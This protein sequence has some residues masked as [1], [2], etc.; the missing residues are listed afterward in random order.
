MTANQA[1]I[2]EGAKVFRKIHK[3]TFP[4]QDGAGATYDF[5]LIPDLDILIKHTNAKLVESRVIFDNNPTTSENLVATMENPDETIHNFKF[6]S[7]DV[8]AV[9]LVRKTAIDLHGI[10]GFKLHWVWAD[11]DDEDWGFTAIF[12]HD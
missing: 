2:E 8:N 10:P 12:E 4:V 11:T 5:G 7:D 3:I 6:S 1:T 9:A